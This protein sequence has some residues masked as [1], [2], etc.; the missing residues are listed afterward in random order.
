MEGGAG[1]SASGEGSRGR[2]EKVFRWSWMCR[3]TGKSTRGAVP[4]RFGTHNI[5]NCLNGGM[6][7][8]VRGMSQAIMDLGIFQETKVT[9]GI[10]TR[11]SAGYSVV[12]TDAPSRHRGGVAVFC[13]PAPHFAVE[14]VHKFGPNVAGFQLATG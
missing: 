11:G 9:D 8:A 2:G 4:I 7:S 10:Y 13:R 1:A 6:E 12:A 5:R 3:S 14:A